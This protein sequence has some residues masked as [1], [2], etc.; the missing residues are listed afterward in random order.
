MAPRT[1]AQKAH[2][3]SMT[4]KCSIAAA[5]EPDPAVKVVECKLKSVQAQL[6]S[7]KDHL[8]TVQ[9][10]LHA[11][12][13]KY[14][15]FYSSTHVERRKYQ[16]TYARKGQLEAQIKILQSAGKVFEKDAAKA[17]ALLDCVTS[18]N[19]LLQQ[20]LSIQMEKCA[21]EAQNTMEKAVMLKAK[22]ATSKQENKNLKLRCARVPEIKARAIR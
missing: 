21:V 7:A 5:A 4:V 1:K 15:A 10:Q 2:L 16:R 22:L 12:K 11:A 9:S 6:D 13:E 14:T 18:E 17:V 3:A 19:T 8:D 20:Q